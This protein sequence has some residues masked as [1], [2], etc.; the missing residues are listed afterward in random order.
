[1]LSRKN[2]KTLLFS[3]V[4]L[5]FAFPNRYGCRVE[6]CLWLISRGFRVDSD[7]NLHL[8]ESQNFTEIFPCF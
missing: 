2:T 8:I 6:D 4:C 7:L 5:D 3:K 1:M